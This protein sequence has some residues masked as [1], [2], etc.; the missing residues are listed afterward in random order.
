VKR[1]NTIG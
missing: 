1:I